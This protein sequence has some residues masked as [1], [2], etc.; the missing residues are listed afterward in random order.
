MSV[1]L[2]TAAERRRRRWKDVWMHAWM[3]G[4]DGWMGGGW[5]V[6]AAAA[7]AAIPVATTLW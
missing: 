7:A 6:R 3:E 5:M 2:S 4:G 1:C